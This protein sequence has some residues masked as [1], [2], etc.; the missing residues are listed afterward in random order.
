MQLSDSFPFE[1]LQNP[2]S[3]KDLGHCSWLGSVWSLSFLFFMKVTTR[4]VYSKE[5][6]ASL[7]WELKLSSLV[8]VSPLSGRALILRR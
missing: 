5:E 6:V 3:R 7:I 1:H 8:V 2:T 4:G